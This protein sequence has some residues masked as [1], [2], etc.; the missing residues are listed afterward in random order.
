[1]NVAIGNLKY[2]NVQLIFGPRYEGALRDLER[3]LA[4]LYPDKGSSRPS[5]ARASVSASSRFVE[6]AENRRA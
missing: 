6:C 2:E 3:D 5:E 4:F 1:M